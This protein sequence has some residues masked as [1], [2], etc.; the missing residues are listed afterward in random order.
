MAVYQKMNP[1]KSLSH[2][3]L[4][5]WLRVSPWF[6]LVGMIFW[7][8]SLTTFNLSIDQ[9]TALFRHNHRVWISQGR[10]AIFFF[11]KYLYPN[12]VT[13]YAP[14]LIFL[15]SLTLSYVFLLD[16][17]RFSKKEKGIAI[18]GS[19][20][21][22]AHPFWYF[23][24]EFYTNIVP[25]GVGML[26]CSLSLWLFAQQP[27]TS[28]LWRFGATLAQIALI[29]FALGNYQ[30]YLLVMIALYLAFFIQKSITE[31]TP[32]TRLGKHAAS[33]L[34]YLICALLINQLWLYL[35]YAITN[36]APSYVG[37]LIQLDVLLAHPLQVITATYQQVLTVYLGKTILYQ[38]PLF[39]LGWL[40]GLGLIALLYQSLKT[41]RLRIVLP[42]LG[43]LLASPFLLHLAAGGFWHMPLRTALAV[44][45]I[46]WFIA[47][48]AYHTFGQ[49]PW[50]RLAILALIIGANVQILQTQA[51]YS[52][53]TRLK[54]DYDKSIAAQLSQRILHA[55][56]DYD[57]NQ[58][59][60]FSV[61]GGLFYHSPYAGVPTT[62]MAGSFF[63]WDEGN[64]ER[65]SRYLQT[66]GLRGLTPI[67]PNQQDQLTPIYDQM[68]LWPAQGAVAVH[69]GVILVK[70][71]EKR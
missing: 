37:S 18:V 44:P 20:L 17:F 41:Q 8:G 33:A 2:V 38:S 70:F 45:V 46:T 42:L 53:T 26:S 57:L 51:Y 23:I 55:L 10:W 59:Y 65:I 6:F 50:G 27:P 14:H 7:F 43:L 12:P 63:W 19:I 40:F 58:S 32:F 60:P 21:F 39:L 56:P 52:T 22:I 13:Y 62:T 24:A 3:S 49:Q 69:D 34:T 5:H 28:R 31:R 16:T 67:T 66:Q 25:A 1:L 9:E 61:Q 29:V 48:I 71:A 68:P 11:T 64:A 35:L 47:S 4:H 30:A 15:F 54:L 36:T